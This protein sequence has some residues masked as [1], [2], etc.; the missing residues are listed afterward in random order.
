MPWVATGVGAVLLLLYRRGH[1]EGTWLLL[2]GVLGP[3][4]APIAI[5][6]IEELPAMERRRLERQ[7][8]PS[9]DE[10]ESD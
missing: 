9:G 7:T 1:S 3:L 2:G 10:A 5:E 8:E 6:R 4:I